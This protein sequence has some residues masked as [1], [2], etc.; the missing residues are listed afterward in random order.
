MTKPKVLI[1]RELYDRYDKIGQILGS[2]AD[3]VFTDRQKYEEQ[4]ADAVGMIGGRI[5]EDVL[6]MAPNLKIVA[7]YGVGYDDCDVEAMTRH[8]VYLSHTP[9][10]LSDAVADMA[11]ALL[12]AVDR[13]LVNCD[14][15]VRSGWADRAP[16]RPSFGVDLRGKTIGIIGLGRIGFEMAKR[17]VKGFDMKLIY[18]DL[19]PSKRAE[20][21][22]GAERKSLEEVMKESDFISIHLALTA[23]TRGL[24]GEKQLKM[25]KKTA[26]IIN[27]SRGPVINQADLTKVLSEGA[28]AGAGIDV[29]EK[30]PIPLD[31]PLLKL[32]NVVLAPHQASVTNEAREGMAVCDAENIAAVLKGELPPP[33]AVPEQRGMIFKK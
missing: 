2:I 17:C 23:Q 27:T 19:Y 9:G 12:L 25:M 31:A 5:T 33:N 18:Y 16:G 14:A 20:E 22:L 30:E 29:F 8:Q 7:R 24:I 1:S 3:V 26:Y 11:I 28:I 6:Q 10:V 13:Q 4:L 21:E 15:Y 32:K